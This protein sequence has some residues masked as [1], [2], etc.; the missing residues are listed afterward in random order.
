MQIMVIIGSLSLSMTVLSHTRTRFH[1]RTGRQSRIVLS[2]LPRLIIIIS[3]HIRLWP[4]GAPRRGFQF[5]EVD[6]GRPH[7]GMAE[8]A[9]LEDE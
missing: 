2:P 1:P 5:H 6:R 9:E 4:P 7:A 8:R 3:I